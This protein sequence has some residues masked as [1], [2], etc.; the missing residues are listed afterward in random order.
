MT[1]SNAPQCLFVIHASNLPHLQSDLRLLFTDF[2]SFSTN[3]CLAFLPEHF[4]VY[5]ASCSAS[6]KSGVR[7]RTPETVTG[8]DGKQYRA[9]RPTA[10]GDAGHVVPV[11]A[12][13]RSRSQARSPRRGQGR[14]PRTPASAAASKSFR[15]RLA[16]RDITETG[17]A[18]G[19]G[20]GRRQVDDP[21]AD[22]GTTVGNGD[23]DRAVVPRDARSRRQSVESSIGPQNAIFLSPAWR[24]HSFPSSRQGRHV[25]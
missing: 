23:N 15:I 17:E 4:A 5:R 25:P 21:A 8:R 11:L 1:L 13:P 7:C 20:A 2:G 22:E 12:A 14:G 6:G 19:M 10:P 24:F 3:L 9:N 18:Q 16:H